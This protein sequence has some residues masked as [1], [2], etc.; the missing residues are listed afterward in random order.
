MAGTVHVLP[1]NR[2]E[3]ECVVE[4]LKR[5]NIDAQAGWPSAEAQSGCAGVVV[6]A[7]DGVA[8]ERLVRE[9]RTTLADS[10]VL[11]STGA[12]DPAAPEGVDGVP[13]LLTRLTDSTTSLTAAVRE[14]LDGRRVGRPSAAPGHSTITLDTLT[15]RELE[16]AA[17]LAAGWRN[18]E[19]AD[20]L[21]I[22]AHTV[23]TH[24]QRVLGKLDVHHRLGLAAKLP[25]QGTAS[26]PRRTVAHVRTATQ[27]P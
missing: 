16:I 11:V 1:A 23:R 20:E 18:E 19:I 22:S 9:A 17:M 13:D 12:E 6:L 2:L 24:V 15:R 8:V 26:R 27:A 14:M 25:Q 7:L 5:G 4:A 21:G 10:P 3:T